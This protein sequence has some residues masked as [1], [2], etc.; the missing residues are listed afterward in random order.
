MVIVKVPT[1]NMIDAQTQFLQET[2]KTEVKLNE[3][4]GWLQ[5]GRIAKEKKEEKIRNKETEKMELKD[6]ELKDSN[7]MTAKEKKAVLK[8]WE[9][10][11]KDGVKTKD[12]SKKL[13]YHLARHCDFTAHRDQ[14]GFYATYFDN[15]DQSIKFL[16]QF[17]KDS[18][19]MSVEYGTAWW[20]DR[21]EYKDVN[22]EMCKIADE[23]KTGLYER[24]KDNAKSR[25][26]E[27]AKKLLE[28]HGISV[29]LE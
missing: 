13:Y 26:I 15:P 20:M 21:G 17:D 7:F 27:M 24:L 12:F 5:D 6:I 2:G 3:F 19:C 1:V 28:K 11:L 14:Y 25:D 10:F 8:H 9:K 29:D 18:G 16:R 4:F 22:S 23:Y